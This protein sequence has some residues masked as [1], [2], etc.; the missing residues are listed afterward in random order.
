MKKIITIAIL[1][2][3]TYNHAQAQ[4]INIIDDDGSEILNAYYKDIDNRLNTYEGTW[5]FQ[6]SS[7]YLKIVLVKK[8][9]EFNGKY[10]ED[11]IVGEYQYIENGV[12]KVNTLSEINIDYPGQN[13]HNISGNFL[14]K[15]TSKPFCS[16][17]LV[18][19]KRLK[20]G[21]TEPNKG[22][23]GELI[24]KKTTTINGFE[25][26]K[27]LIRDTGTSTINIVGQPQYDNC[28]SVPVGEYTLIKQ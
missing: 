8:L 9:N 19:E 11:L 17:C 14:I 12:E 27:I 20:L 16:D 21:L 25:A 23:Y 26:I 2:F 4:T 24:V 28:F 5:L 3:I 7:K 13:D 10:Y 1:Y 6:N 15:K 22:V 18:D